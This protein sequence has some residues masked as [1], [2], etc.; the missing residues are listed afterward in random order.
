MK[1]RQPEH[2]LIHLSIP[3]IPPSPNRG[4]G[5]IG[6]SIWKSVKAERRAW[7]MEL[8]FALRNL[9]GFKGWEHNG[10]RRRVV[11][12]QYR[13]R[14][15]DPDNATAACK[16][17]LDAMRDLQLIKQDSEKWIELEVRQVTDKE[18]KTTIAIEDICQ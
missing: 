16:R 6:W 3:R 9:M 7:C 1:R 13:K 18:E 15:L 12:T 4:L 14:L 11:I 8:S 2:Q 10:R 5:V 17:L